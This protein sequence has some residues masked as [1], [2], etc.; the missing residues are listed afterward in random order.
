MKDF[1]KNNL[2]QIIIILILVFVIFLQ[3]CGVKYT[4]TV[5]NQSEL[6]QAVNHVKDSL[7]S[8]HYNELLANYKAGQQAEEK[9]TDAI[10]RKL[11]QTNANAAELKLKNDSLKKLI[12]VKDTLCN[13]VVTSMQAEIDTINTENVLLNNKAESYSRQLYLCEKQSVLKDTVIMNK[14]SLLSETNRIND[15]LKKDLKRKNN[16][17][18]RNK[19]WLGVI[20]G[21]VGTWLIVK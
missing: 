5:M 18:N 9:K 13:M 15:Q 1:V 21:A 10:Q 19:I 14:T 2:I 7:Q 8:V 3:K 4:D 20:A 11:T 17:F 6:Q 16:W 12:P